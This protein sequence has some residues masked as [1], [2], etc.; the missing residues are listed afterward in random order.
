MHAKNWTA[1]PLGCLETWPQ[2]VETAVSACL[3][4]RFPRP[5]IGPMLDEVRHRTSAEDFQ[6][7][8]LPLEESYFS[9]GYSSIL[10][11]DGCTIDGVFC[12]CIETTEKVVRQRRL[13]T[14]RDLRT[15][16]AGQRT[17]EVSCLVA[18]EKASPMLPSGEESDVWEAL[19]D[20]PCFL[21]SDVPGVKSRVL[22]VEDNGDTPD[23]LC[24]LLSKRWDVDA[25]RDGLA[26]LDKVKQHPP[27]LIL[28]D[29]TMPGLDGTGLLT[30]LRADLDLAEIPVILFSALRR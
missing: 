25:I 9:H 2:G 8:Q 27:D 26:V 6:M 3:N 5:L 28:A 18:A 4:S 11:S 17:A 16:A 30:A 20:K 13:T 19:I 7:V 15:R 1:S 12:A 10:S 24:H 23:Q 21:E 14:S 29:I 22:V